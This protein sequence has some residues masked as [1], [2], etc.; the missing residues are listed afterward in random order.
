MRLFVAIPLPPALAATAFAAI[1]DLPALRRVRPEHLHITLAFLG[2]TDESR[3]DD[4][5][6]AVGAA[7]TSAAPFDASLDTLG[8]FPAGGVPRIVWLGAGIGAAEL[9]TLAAAV[10]RELTARGL[11]YDAKPFRPH[12][13]LARVR[14]NVDRDTAR[15][16]AAVVERARPPELRFRAA[17]VVLFESV[18]SAGGPR[19]T[20]RGSRSLGV[21]GTE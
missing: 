19:Y 3:L 2:P 17:E 7:A 6:A 14:E 12:V 8:R 18:L 20:R 1:P 16:V 4:A 9:Q 5:V 10:R 11:Q 21:G 15:A 13:T